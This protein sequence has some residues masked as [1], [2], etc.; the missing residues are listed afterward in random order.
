M[1]EYNPSA[2]RKNIIIH[3]NARFTILTDRILRLE[4]ADDGN[5]EDHATLAV[6]NR[7]TPAVNLRQKVEDEKLVFETDHLKLTY[8]DTGRGSDHP[9]RPVSRHPIMTVP[10]IAGV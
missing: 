4:W 2:L 1:T 8:R 7:R 6:I 5:F 10:K 9:Y 3:G